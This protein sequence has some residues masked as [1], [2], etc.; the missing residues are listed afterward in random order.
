MIYEFNADDVTHDIPNPFRIENIF[1]A[2]SG[3]AMFTGG[4][5]VLQIARG[6]YVDD[7]TNIGTATVILAFALFATAVKFGIQALSQMRFFFGRNFPL[8]LAP[9]LLPSAQGVSDESK[10]I[11]EKLRQRSIYFLEPKGPLNGVFYS[12]IK[13]LI[14][15]PPTIQ[16][17]A[18]R[19]FHGII[20][21]IAIL[22]SMT[23]SYFLFLD[24][25]AE[26]LISWIYLPMSGL[27]LATPFLRKEGGNI[28]PDSNLLL[29][30][31]CGLV[32]FAIL[33]PV[34]ASKYL[35]H[36]PILPMWI[37]PLAL[38]VTSI[39]ASV[40]FLSSLLAKLG[41]TTQTAVS[42]EQKKIAMNCAPSQL[43]A[44]I[45]R[46]F[47]NG[48]TRNIPNRAYINLP[49]NTTTGERGSFQGHIL[50]ESQ[51]TISSTMRFDSIMEALAA[52]NARFLVLLNLWGVVL[53]VAIAISGVWLADRF[54]DMAP[55]EISR[56]LLTVFA[57]VA[58]TVLAFRIGH[59][60]WSRMYYKSRLIWIETEGT[61]QTSELDIGN[62][63]FGRVRSRNNLTRV[64]DATLRIWV[65]ETISVGF[66]KEGRRFIIAMAPAD[67][68]ARSLADHLIKFAAEQSSI[69]TPISTRDV[70]KADHLAEFEAAM[71]DS[72]TEESGGIINDGSPKKICSG[73]T[74]NCVG[75]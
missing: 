13:N 10:L 53:S 56:S 50:E 55:F 6:Y 61:F 23:F 59:L 27:S 40:L 66:G 49:P 25:P 21:M 41:G 18:V 5:Y 31:L 68:Y 69:V 38:L 47:Q 75:Q 14:V 12:L 3:I 39:I 67:R 60:L 71:G 72:K 46:E 19:H 28:P 51:P 57:L 65:T 48:W 54:F 20:G 37:A 16:Y 9:E 44:E 29:W 36:F 45:S 17:A 34:L 24:K 42:L 43:W 32:T 33:A 1:L 8:G 11:Q 58:S 35:P 22:V 62:Q 73:T 70:F 64:E 7:M 30:D 26:G 2:I 74:K 4:A 15:A 52:P 63:T